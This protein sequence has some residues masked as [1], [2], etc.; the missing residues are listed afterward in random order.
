MQLPSP[1]LCAAASRLT[2][3]VAWATGH[4]SSFGDAWPSAAADV[5]ASL[6]ALPALKALHYDA[7]LVQG[8]GGGEVPALVAALRQAKPGL[9]LYTPRSARVYKSGW[10][11]LGAPFGW[12]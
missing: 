10:P 12:S 9:Q 2:G 11:D 1:E 8:A 5:L 3:L 4:E 7:E 6:S